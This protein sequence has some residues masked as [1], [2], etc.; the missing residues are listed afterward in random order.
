MRIETETEYVIC[1]T[2]TASGRS[3]HTGIYAAASAVNALA[4]EGGRDYSIS[5]EL[6]LPEKM[7]KEYVYRMEKQIRKMC[8]GKNIVLQEITECVQPQ[9]TECTV[10]VTGMARVPKEKS[11]YKETMRAGQ[12]IVLINWIGTEGIIRILASQRERLGKRFAAG[13]LSQAAQYEPEIF[14]L[15]EAQIA[16]TCRPSCIM[17]VGEGGIFAALW[18]LACK[19]GTGLEADMKKISIRQETIE[20]CEYFRINPYQ[21][22]SAGTL[23]VVTGHGEQLRESCA[24]EGIH[25]SVIG[26]LKENHDKVIRNGEDV[27]YIDRPAPDEI[28]KIRN[29]GFYYERNQK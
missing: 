4:C 22:A 12:D 6:L 10:V 24:R 7:Q 23:L 17:Q 2:G 25:A 15:K 3:E 26:Q 11:W 16:E 20:I 5:A 28:N 27:R 19:S 18:R 29:E 1:K 21:L 13:F 9:I 8:A 14:A